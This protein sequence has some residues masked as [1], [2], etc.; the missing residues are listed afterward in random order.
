MWTCGLNLGRKSL[1]NSVT[2]HLPKN[3][4]HFRA[5]C[6]SQYLLCRRFIM[7]GNYSIMKNQHMHLYNY[8]CCLLTTPKYMG[9]VWRICPRFVTHNS[10]LYSLILYTL[11]MVAEGDRNML[12]WL[13]NKVYN[14]KC[15]CWFFHIACLNTRYGTSWG[16]YLGPRG[17]R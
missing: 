13:I 9:C 16:G 12:V 14:Y 17:M 1:T 3:S 5:T 10:L 7:R 2:T 4:Q 11:R 6:Y 8:I 15:I